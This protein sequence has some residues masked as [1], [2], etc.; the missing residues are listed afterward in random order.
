MLKRYLPQ[1][2]TVCQTV[3]YFHYRSKSTYLSCHNFNWNLEITRSYPKSQ[4]HGKNHLSDLK[5][6]PILQPWCK[7][8]YLMFECFI[9]VNRI[10]KDFEFLPTINLWTDV[11]Q[12]IYKNK[13]SWVKKNWSRIVAMRRILPRQTLSLEAKTKILALKRVFELTSEQRVYGKLR[14]KPIFLANFEMFWFQTKRSFRIYSMA[15]Q[16]YLY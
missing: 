14:G 13:M 9:F 3:L 12:S 1:S 4:T 2:V 11:L 15:S 8:H 5:Y 6:P 16:T 7:K 10:S